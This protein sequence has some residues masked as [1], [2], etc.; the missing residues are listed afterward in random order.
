MA[1][2]TLAARGWL[3]VRA[4][5]ILQR[6]CCSTAV[7]PAITGAGHPCGCTAS[8]HQCAISNQSLKL[9]PRNGCRGGRRDDGGAAAA[10]SEQ[11][12]AV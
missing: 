7:R 6:S 1:T 8:V 9:C 2:V 3:L 10:S 5:R 11:S 4:A 12:V